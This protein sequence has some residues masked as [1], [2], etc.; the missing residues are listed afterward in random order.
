MENEVKYSLSPNKFNELVLELLL[1]LCIEQDAFKN[2]IM[3]EFVNRDNN[4]LDS[5]KELD[6]LNKAYFE[7]KASA[8]QHHLVQI[9]NKYGLDDS[10]DDLLN[11]AF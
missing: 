4:N 9:K 6:S 5:Q 8:K 3:N 10:V 1:K 11:S 2:L 7:L